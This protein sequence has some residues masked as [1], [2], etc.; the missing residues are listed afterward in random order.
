MS[1]AWVKDSC[2]KG[3]T[4]C[5]QTPPPLP[6]GKIGGGAPSPIFPEGKG[7]GEGCTQAKGTEKPVG[8]L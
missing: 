6:S 2:F 8:K 1:L 4:A 7:G 3:T 5:V